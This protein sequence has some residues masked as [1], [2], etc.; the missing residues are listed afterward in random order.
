MKIRYFLFPVI[1]TLLLAEGLLRIF[2]P[3]YYPDNYR[4]YR[5]DPAAGY[6]LKSSLHSFRTTDYQEE[7]LTNRSGTANFQKDFSG[8]KYK[9]FAMGDSLTQ[10][11][12]LPAD[13]SY[14][15]QLNLLLNVR[16]GR[17]FKDY[18]VVNL[19]VAG[20]GVKQAI[21]RLKEYG[22]KIGKPRYILFLGCDNDVGDDQ[23]F[24]AGAVHHKRLEGNPRFSPFLVR[25][26]LW[27]KYD[28]EIGKRLSFLHK[29]RRR[30]QTV[31]QKVVNP[32]NSAEL[33]EPAFKELMNVSRGMGATLILSWMPVRL[34]TQMPPEYRW[35]QEFCRRQ[36]LPFADWF[37]MA[38]AIREQIPALPFENNHSAGHYRT[39]VN[40]MVARGFAQQIRQHRV[41]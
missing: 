3:L 31:A 26:W 6:R 41:P 38:R 14:P 10:G 40:S 36:G 8:Y 23:A 32:Q 20:Y 27:L 39:W 33:L 12:G 34:S 28:T 30:Q 37:P 7:L 21:V 17:Y 16:D 35:L 5:Y 29:I 1:F 24:L 11:I 4:I 15:F 19:G 9:V 25:S 2:W 13:A 22:E 18:G